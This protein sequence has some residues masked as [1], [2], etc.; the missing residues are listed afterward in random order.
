MKEVETTYLAEVIEKA[1]ENYEFECI[2]IQG[3]QGSGK[4]HYALYT[5]RSLYGSWEE[6]LYNLVF[7]PFSTLPRLR[8]AVANEYRIKAMCYD[9]AG[10]WLSKYLYF[11]KG[12][13]FIVM[14]MNSLINL[15]RTCCAAIIY[16]SPDPDILKE[17]R[18]K[19]W[20]VVDIVKTNRK[21]WRKAIIY[22]K[23]IRPTGFTTL[24]LLSEETFPLLKIPK[25]VWQDYN[26]MR[27]AATL[28]TI[29]SLLAFI[30]QHR[31]VLQAIMSPQFARL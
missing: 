26:V 24:K 3:K 16:T 7:N 10:K 13:K 19:V 11:F 23:K 21:R 30:E 27:K 6:A 2:M 22:R 12:G 14:S 31:D 25:T 15:M 9:D 20:I 8:D 5:L 29:D 1:Y 28:E 17:L 4:T 18:K